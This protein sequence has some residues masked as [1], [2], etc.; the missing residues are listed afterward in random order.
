MATPPFR[1][2]HVGSLLRPQSVVQFA[3]VK[4]RTVFPAI[5]EKLDF[6]D[7]HDQRGIAPQCS[8]AST[9]EGNKLSA[10]DQRRE[11]EFVVQ[12]TEIVCG[13]VAA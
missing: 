12:T 8:S 6:P 7:D 2:D 11:L 13:G 3:G 9:E 4:L 5:Q 1:A 10:D